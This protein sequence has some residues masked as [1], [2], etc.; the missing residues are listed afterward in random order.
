MAELTR[1]ASSHKSHQ[2]GL[3]GERLAGRTQ[4]VFFSAED[5]ENYVYPDAYPVDFAKRA[6]L[7]AGPLEPPAINRKIRE[8]MGQGFGTIVVHNPGAKHSLGVG[9]LNRLQLVFE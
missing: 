1:G 6:E 7:D 8:L 2:M 4:T 9:I 5:A 3:H